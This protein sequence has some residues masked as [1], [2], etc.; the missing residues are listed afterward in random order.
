[1]SLAAHVYVAEVVLERARVLKV[2]FIGL[3]PSL[4]NKVLVEIKKEI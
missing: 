1:M 4:R 2:S 3:M